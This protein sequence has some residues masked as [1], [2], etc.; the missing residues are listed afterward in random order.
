M[1][2][3]HNALTEAPSAPV[4]GP[5]A[6]TV[7]PIAAHYSQYR[8]CMSA[9]D[10]AHADSELF[11]FEAMLKDALTLELETMERKGP[12]CLINIFSIT[13][14]WN[15]EYMYSVGSHGAQ[16]MSSSRLRTCVYLGGV[17]LQVRTERCLLCQTQPLQTSRRSREVLVKDPTYSA[18]VSHAIQPN[19]R[20]RTD[21]CYT[22]QSR[23]MTKRGRARYGNSAIS[24]Q[25]EQMGT[26]LEK[27]TPEHRPDIANAIVAIV[28][29][30]APAF[31]TSQCK[32]RSKKTATSKV[33]QKV[34]AA[35]ARIF[36]AASQVG[37]DVSTR[38]PTSLEAVGIMSI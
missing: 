2:E 35:S 13:R 24:P 28:I 12:I 4:A 7:L 33:A 22:A 26:L 29:S 1:V 21:L 23:P 20:F 11:N 5:V 6:N 34:D 30:T 19:Y 27:Y 3:G 18:A 15:W 37:F 36:K 14:R 31:A 38:L 16:A 32:K 17:L 10:V 25:S 8:L 9:D